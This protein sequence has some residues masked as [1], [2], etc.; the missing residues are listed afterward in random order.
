[1]DLLDEPS[2]YLSFSARFLLLDFLNKYFCRLSNSIDQL[3][4]NIKVM[5]DNKMV[6]SEG[7]ECMCALR[8][9][10][11]TKRQLAFRGKEILIYKL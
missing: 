6:E 10:Y 9:I 2:L 1:M 3:Y 4:N 5:V 11:K 7:H 8:L